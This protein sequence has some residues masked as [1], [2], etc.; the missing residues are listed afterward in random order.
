MT[1]EPARA[2]A[3]RSRAYL[4]LCSAVTLIAAGLVW[5]SQTM[6]F[7]WDEGFHMLCAQLIA[8]GRRPYVDF[9]FCQTPLNAYWN[10]L[11]LT[12]FGQTWRVPH[13]IAAVCVAGAV[14]LMADYVFERVPVPRWRLA[15]ALV[16][17]L[18][19]GLNIAVVDYGTL[20]QAYGLCLLLIA[21]AFRFSVAGVDRSSPALAAAAGLASGAA[22]CASL[23][24]APV[25]P[26]LLLWMLVANR[27]GRRRVKAAAFIVGAAVSFL[28]V[29][30]LYVQSPRN[31]VFGIL[32][33]NLLFRAVQ[34]EGSWRQNFEVYFSWIDSSHALLLILLGAAGLFFV[35]FRSDWERRVRSELYLCG[36]LA[37]ALSVHISTA[38]PTFSRY[39]LL[40]VPFLALL[41]AAGFYWVATRLFHPGRPL[42]P[43]LALV[44]LVTLMQGQS[45][46]ESR[47]DFTWHTLDGVSKKVAEVTPPN[48][49]LR[50]DEQVYFLSQHRP[51]S[52]MELADSHKLEF[53]PA[54][55]AQLH[56]MSG[57]E[58]ERRTKAGD[59][60]TFQTCDDESDFPSLGLDRLYA[61]KATV[62][63][64]TVFW[65]PNRAPATAAAS[66]H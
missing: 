8:A 25:A 14:L 39:Y 64:C 22:A 24:T 21:A 27:A 10:A 32:Q 35:A 43:T 31:V 17:A 48:A 2:P 40:A 54:L 58:L 20:G 23:L 50:A 52:G 56:L 13:A 62:E 41:A 60:D 55:N 5:Y 9:A 47:D 44:L 63:S 28:P 37:L 51:P 61:H 18:L 49:L 36:W 34:W 16:A 53:P 42:W 29:L 6:A 15:A 30:A 26:V 7:A 66:G 65:G 1:P 12:I 57:K 33:Y 38:R 45:L 4:F 3:R 46:Y 59:F 11:W 19:F